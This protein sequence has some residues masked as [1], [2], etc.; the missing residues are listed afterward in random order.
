[1]IRLANYL[2]TQYILKTG[3]AMNHDGP[4]KL[5]IPTDEKTFQQTDASSCGIHLLMQATS[6]V[7]KRKFVVIN[8]DNVQFY[9][10]QIAETILRR[11][12]PV[13]E[14][15]NDSVSIFDKKYLYFME[16]SFIAT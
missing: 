8:D 15:S 2:N 1:M 11:A 9:R 4:W 3:N 13:S 6:Y 12:E 10:Y 7:Q 5:A 16:C 14:D